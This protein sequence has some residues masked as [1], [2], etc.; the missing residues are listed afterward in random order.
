[1]LF[2]LRYIIYVPHANEIQF[3]ITYR[4]KKKS[5]RIHL[6]YS[7]HLHSEVSQ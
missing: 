7:Y 5:F 6:S 2:T 3:K 4:L 1:M